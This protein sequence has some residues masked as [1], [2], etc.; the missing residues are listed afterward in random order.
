MAEQRHLLIVHNDRQVREVLHQIFVG[1]GYNCLLASDGRAGLKAFRKSR[2]WLIV[3]QLNL[4]HRLPFSGVFA[5][6][7]LLKQVRREDPDAAVIVVSGSLHRETATECLKLGADAYIMTP[8]NVDELL[9]AAERAL[10]RRHLRP[11]KPRNRDGAS[12]VRGGAGSRGAGARRGVRLDSMTRTPEQFLAA[13]EFHLKTSDPQFADG[14]PIIRNWIALRA[15]TVVLQAEFDDLI[16]RF[17]GSS[18]GSQIFWL[19]ND[20]VSWGTE[21]GLTV[22]TRHPWRA[23]GS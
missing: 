4:P 18:E 20:I 19:W 5:G 12:A 15:R 22:P 14:I 8:L 2:P 10:E 9:I 7:E 13:F 11:P 3:T 16:G 21:R 17:E 6:I 23:A 1:A